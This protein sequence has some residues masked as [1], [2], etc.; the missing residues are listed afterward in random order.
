MQN[1][2]E[3]RED[4]FPASCLSAHTNSIRSWNISFNMSNP[5]SSD[6]RENIFMAMNLIWFLLAFLPP[7]FIFLLGYPHALYYVPGS[8]HFN[9]TTPYVLFQLIFQRIMM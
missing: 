6:L 3:A 1:S 5:G 2:L 7:V 9:P 4:K 8:F